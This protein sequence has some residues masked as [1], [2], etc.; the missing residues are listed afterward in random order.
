MQNGKNEDRV[1]L[2][3]RDDGMTGDRLYKGDTV[4]VVEEE[5]AQDDILAISTKSGLLIRRIQPVG[6]SYLLI[7]SNPDM[8]N[9]RCEHVLILGRV[10]R[11]MLTF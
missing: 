1:F 7:A 2:I 6:S 9:E 4:E 3:V 5:F 10:T 11:A 8:Q